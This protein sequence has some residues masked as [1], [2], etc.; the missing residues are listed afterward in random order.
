LLKIL[1]LQTTFSAILP[2]GIR[3]TSTRLRSL[4]STSNCEKIS[5]ERGAFHILLA[6]FGHRQIQLGEQ[7]NQYRLANSLPT[8]KQ[9]S[10]HGLAM[11]QG[12]QTT[13]GH[14][15][16]QNDIKAVEKAKKTA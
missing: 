13:S 5:I 2:T 14:P 9:I 3:L 4:L 15:K 7:R 12:S 6:R 10:M 8:V 11:I 1:S 16:Q